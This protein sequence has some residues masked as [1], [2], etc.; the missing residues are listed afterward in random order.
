MNGVDIP[1]PPAT[2]GTLW[3]PREALLSIAFNCLLGLL[4]Y[5]TEAITTPFDRTT[6]RSLQGDTSQ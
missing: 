5:A 1:A 4:P 3:L 2:G 6:L